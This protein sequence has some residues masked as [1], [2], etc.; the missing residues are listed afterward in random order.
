MVRI[1]DT[2]KSILLSSHSSTS[3]SEHQYNEILHQSKKSVI[4]F[5]IAGIAYNFFQSNRTSILLLYAE[6]FSA[7]PWQIAMLLNGKEV[8]C[9]IASLV[10]STLAN[11]WG[12]DTILTFVLLLQFIAVFSEAIAQSFSVLFIGTTLG[13]VAIPF[14]VF[15]YI[16]WILPHS[17]ATRYIAYY[18][19]TATGGVLLG[20][21]SAGF[22]SYYLS[23]RT[24]F[25]INAVIAFIC[26]I[27]SVTCI[28][29]TQKTL[30]RQ[31]LLVGVMDDKEVDEQFPI[32]L[33]NETD[34]D[35]WYTLPQLPCH[36]WFM[37]IGILL[38][39]STV[40]TAECAF[41]TYYPLYIVNV[42]HGNVIIGTS[43]IAVVSVAFVVGS[44]IVPRWCVSSK[45]LENADI[46]LIKNKY[47]VIIVSLILLIIQFC[48]FPGVASVSLYWVNVLNITVG[49][50]SG[51]LAMS[52]E[53]IVLEIQPAKFSG[54]VSGL[55][56]VIGNVLAA[57]T[58]P[59]IALFWEQ[60]PNLFYYLIG[61]IWACALL[62]TITI[63]GADR[64]NGS[65]MHA[66]RARGV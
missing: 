15:G 26:L 23:N 16:P 24:V 31:Q 2:R 57:T 50:T 58:L 30:E 52:L 28:W 37:L 54:K 6:E 34:N 56:G 38:I 11:Q 59:I 39:N 1:H 64:K 45:E 60:D 29:N 33:H 63:I 36:E 35:K 44:L 66:Q 13:Q 55:K 8:C 18:Y 43:G 5:L 19:G 4:Q 14:I 65:K 20:P 53:M 49:F 21:L 42:L 25:I 9:G 47:F 3:D 46:P 32:C 61:G 17:D 27:C 51:I 10:Y 41:V 48:L 22:V 12:Y 40:L 62:L 7:T